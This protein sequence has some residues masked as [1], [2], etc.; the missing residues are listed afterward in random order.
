[1]ALQLFGAEQFCAERRFG[2]RA[3][4]RRTTFGKPA[5]P[6]KANVFDEIGQVVKNGR[7]LPAMRVIRFQNRK[8]DLHST[9]PFNAS[10][11]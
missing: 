11:V 7:G 3:T 6:S 9:L 10:L 8:L 2:F 4:M 1:M 5:I